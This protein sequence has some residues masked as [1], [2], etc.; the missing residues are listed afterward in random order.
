MRYTTFGRQTGLRVS[1]LAL[2]TGSFGWGHGAEPAEARRLFDR[3]AEAGFPHEAMMAQGFG[4]RIAGG[5]P[6]LLTPRGV[7]AA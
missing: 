6:E 3:Y 7:P 1:E 5:R 4:L 2:G